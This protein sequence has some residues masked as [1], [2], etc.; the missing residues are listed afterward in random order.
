[1]DPWGYYLRYANTRNPAFLTVDILVF[2]LAMYGLLSAIRRHDQFA[3]LAAVVIFYVLLVSTT[4]VK[5]DPRYR[6]IADPLLFMFAAKAV[7]CI[8][9]RPIFQVS[10]FASGK[11]SN[12]E[13][14]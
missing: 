13:H 9:R 5:F 10:S 8:L 7:V 14:L 12:D 4:V 3:F 1:V 2:V 11:E 6:S